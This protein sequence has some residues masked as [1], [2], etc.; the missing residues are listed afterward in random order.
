[1]APRPVGQPNIKNKTVPQP[2]MGPTVQ[3]PP[4]Q[5][6]H[7]TY[8]GIGNGP[9]PVIDGATPSPMANANARAQQARPPQLEQP[10]YGSSEVVGNPG[11]QTVYSGDYGTTTRANDVGQNGSGLTPGNISP[12]RAAQAE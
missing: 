11:A 7:G 2:Y 9:K 10:N 3:G 5:S 6:T 12:E 1:M 8:N 4:Q